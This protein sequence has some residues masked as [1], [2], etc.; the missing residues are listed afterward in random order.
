M[1]LK[2]LMLNINTG[3]LN[4]SVIHCGPIEVQKIRSTG[5]DFLVVFFFFKYKYRKI[6]LDLRC[7]TSVLGL[8]RPIKKINGLHYQLRAHK[9]AKRMWLKGFDR[10]TCHG[11]ALLHVHWCLLIYLCNGI[12]PPQV[13]K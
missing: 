11:E 4:G 13:C 6:F 8:I 5:Y 9:N 12:P 2:V 7:E 10:A 3:I 1:K